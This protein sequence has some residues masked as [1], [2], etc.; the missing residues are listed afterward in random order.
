MRWSPAL[1]H[2]GW[3]T[4]RPI[5]HRGLHNAKKGI[6]ENSRSAFAGAIEAGYAIEC[7]LQISRD[8][9]AVVFHDETLDRLMETKGMVADHSAPELQAMGFKAGGDHIQTLSELLAQVQGRVPLVIEIKSI[10]NGE[11]ALARRA[12]EA[13]KDYDGPF[14]FMSF[15]PRVMVAVRKF[16]PDLA[17]GMVAD[18]VTHPDYDVLPLGERVALR[19]FV[20]IGDTQPDFIS[21]HWRD[22]P[23]AAV[24]QFRETGRPVISWTI[25]SQADAVVARRYS[26]Q[27]TFEGFRA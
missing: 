26:D 7:D 25:R 5:A 19:E 18:R 17:R 22:L 15:D 13:V 27:I 12:V 23:F 8:G 2:L 10:W 14:A 21:Y 11:E 4:A 9:E 24:S 16:A 6:I 3:L 20:H 1:R